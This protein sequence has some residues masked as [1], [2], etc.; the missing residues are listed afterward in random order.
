MPEIVRGVGDNEEPPPRGEREH[1]SEGHHDEIHPSEATTMRSRTRVI[2][3]A[4]RYVV[5]CISAGLATQRR[6]RPAR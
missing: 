2:E 6:R 4:T 5:I 1:S 3:F